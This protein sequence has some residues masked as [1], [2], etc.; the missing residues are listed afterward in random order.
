GAAHDRPDWRT[1]ADGVITLLL[2][3]LRRPQV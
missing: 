1:E 3:G 2:D